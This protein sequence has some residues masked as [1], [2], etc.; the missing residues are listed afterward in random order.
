MF[1]CSFF[2]FAAAIV[3]IP[4]FSLYCTLTDYFTAYFTA[5]FCC[6]FF[7][8][9][10]LLLSLSFS[11]LFTAPSLSFIHCPLIFIHC[12]R[13]LLIQLPLFFNSLSFHC[14]FAVFSLLFRVFSLF[15]FLFCFSADVTLKQTLT[16]GNPSTIEFEV[17]NGR[18]NKIEVSIDLEGDGTIDF[19]S[20]PRPLTAVVFG[21]VRLDCHVRCGGER[22]H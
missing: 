21:H 2:A 14:S 18:E 1:S 13:F 17:V 12:P 20:Q 16:S 22:A 9:C 4:L 8:T 10:Y 7:F 3:L 19:K 11:L 6:C 15:C 5:L